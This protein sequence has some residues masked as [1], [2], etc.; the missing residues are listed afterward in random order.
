MY[1]HVR[2]IQNNPQTS[3]CKKVAPNLACVRTPGVSY[4][5]KFQFEDYLP[6]PEYHNILV[7]MFALD[8][9]P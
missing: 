1:M 9:F 2:T 8:R 7:K 3:A 6:M 4:P 5:F